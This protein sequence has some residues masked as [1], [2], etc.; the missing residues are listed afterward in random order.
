MARNVTLPA[1]AAER[2]LVLHG[3]RSYRS[4]SPAGR[5]RS[6]KSAGGRCC[7]SIDR[8]TPDGWARSTLL[9]MLCQQRQLGLHVQCAS[10]QGGPKSGAVHTGTHGH[11]SVKSEPIKVFKNNFTG[12][13]LGK[14]VVKPKWILKIPPPLA[15]VATLRCETLL[16]AKHLKASH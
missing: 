16:S 12:R 10:V 6:S 3:A 13:F 9:R 7:R 8:R 1:F 2:R 4:I 14:F 11:N 15:Y 5:A